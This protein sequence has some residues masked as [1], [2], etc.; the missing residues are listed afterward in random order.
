VKTLGGSIGLPVLAFI[1][2]NVVSAIVSNAFASL[3]TS[4][5]NLIRIPGFSLIMTFT[6]SKSS[7]FAG[8]KYFVFNSS[9]GIN[10]PS[11]SI[12]L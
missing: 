6:V 3:Y 5:S 4:Y 1:K 7:Y 9:T 2:T 11:A 10:I 8:F 12:S